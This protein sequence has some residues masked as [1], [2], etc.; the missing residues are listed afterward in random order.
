[1]YQEEN[2]SAL[3]EKAAALVKGADSL[4][5][6]AGAGMGVDS[7]LP[8]FRGKDGFWQAYPALAERGI[9]LME[10]A[11]P[12][13]F[14]HEPR[15]AWGFYGHR[16]DLYRKT[17]PHEGFAIL[18]KWAE[19]MPKGYSIFTSNVDGQFQKAGF[20]ANHISECHGSI[21]W[22]QC[23]RKCSH[24][25]WPA[26]DFQPVVDTIHC[27]L[28][29]EL[30]LCPYCGATARPNIL[31][32]DDWLWAEIRTGM[33]RAQQENWLKTVQK[34]VVIELGAGSSIPSVRL[35][36]SRIVSRY[37]GSLIRINPHPDD[38]KVARFQ[39]VGLKMGAL[40][41]LRGIALQ[42]HLHP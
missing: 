15:L 23:L 37:G 6:A 7:G 10:I 12:Q 28:K 31:M 29:N 14:H 3:L 21:H 26:D 8:D 2:I 1:M 33:Q 5:I 4:V 36:S 20:S 35:F 25:L 17:V 27:Q 39:D 16:L 40:G 11:N 42:L 30:P 24:K 19:A 41:A 32:F 18:K 38:H 13:T 9:D 34:P 22:M